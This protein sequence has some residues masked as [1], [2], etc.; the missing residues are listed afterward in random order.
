MAS[1][2][3]AVFGGIIVSMNTLFGIYGKVASDKNCVG[4]ECAIINEPAMADVGKYLMYGGLALA[5]TGFV[6]I[7]VTQHHKK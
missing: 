7:L 4:S 3:V 6:H 2:G 5:F 1:G